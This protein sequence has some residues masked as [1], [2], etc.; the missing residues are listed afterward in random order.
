MSGRP[1]SR[2]LRARPTE[3]RKGAD[4]GIDG[5]RYFTDPR[6]GQTEQIIFSV[7]AGHVSVSHVRDLR[8]V[9]EREHAS[10]GALVCRERPTRPMRAEAASAGF[11]DTA[12]G[13]YPRLQIG[14]IDELL[15]GTRLDAPNP[16]DVTYKQAPR[17]LPKVAERQPEFNLQPAEPSRKSKMVKA[18]LPLGFKQ[19]KA[20]QSSKRGR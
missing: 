15:S 6:T 16:L 11:V 18:I 1:I 12:W 9:I 20:R 3:Q 13:R 7:K 17:T 4:R 2:T 10:M 5:R 8:G 14:S 19:P